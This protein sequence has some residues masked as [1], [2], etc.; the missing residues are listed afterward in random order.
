MNYKLYSILFFFIFIIYSCQK[1]EEDKTNNTTPIIGH[2]VKV[3]EVIQANSY[4]YLKVEENNKEYW[5]AIAKST[6]IKKDDIIYYHIALEMKNFISEDLDRTFET[7]LFVDNISDKP[8]KTPHG[9]PVKSPMQ[10]KTSEQDT[11]IAIDPLSSGISI[12]ELYANRESYSNKEI[13][14]K[15]QVTKVNTAIMDRNW[16]HIQDGSEHNG[17][18]DLTITT[19]ANVKIGDIVVFEGIINLNK[20]FGA[21]YIYDLIMEEAKLI[22][23][24]STVL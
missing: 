11:S 22:N 19:Q 1:G 3:L 18:F 7:I 16:V 23:N 5:M 15:G 2:E 17:Q 14:I 21:G 6:A 9:V 20:D 12:A 10:R 4:T 13:K 8:I 24:E